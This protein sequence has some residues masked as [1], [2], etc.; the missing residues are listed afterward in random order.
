[1][2]KNMICDRQRYPTTADRIATL[3]AQ[4][5]C[6]HQTAGSDTHPPSCNR[7]TANAVFPNRRSC[8]YAPYRQSACR[9]FSTG[10]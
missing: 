1:M 5:Q 7:P 9:A 8:R 10:Q 6:Q 3:L 2:I 4:F